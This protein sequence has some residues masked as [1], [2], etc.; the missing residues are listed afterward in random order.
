MEVICLQ[1]EAFYSLIGQEGRL[2]MS[3]TRK[4]PFY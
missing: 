4:S 1:E 2:K 3:R